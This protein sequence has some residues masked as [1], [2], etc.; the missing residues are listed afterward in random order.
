MWQVQRWLCKRNRHV[1]STI[2]SDVLCWHD[3]D[4][5]TVVLHGGRGAVMLDRISSAT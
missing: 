2:A 5:S 3:V 4:H 1:D